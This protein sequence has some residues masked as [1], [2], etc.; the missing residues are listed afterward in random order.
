M[1]NAD[2]WMAVHDATTEIREDGVYL[3]FHCGCG[4]P[5]V[6]TAFIA[7]VLRKM[8]A[9]DAAYVAVPAV[10][11]EGE[12]TPDEVEMLLI[13]FLDNCGLTEHG[14]SVTSG[15]PSPKGD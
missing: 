1:K 12:F 9:G 15:F 4:D 10:L 6:G 5:A 14:G 7:G 2:Y 13:Y 3:S 11:K 8:K